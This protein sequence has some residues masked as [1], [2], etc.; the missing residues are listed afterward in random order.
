MKRKKD[1]DG[2][3]EDKKC[4]KVCTM[5]LNFFSLN[6]GWCCMTVS[7]MSRLHSSIQTQIS[8]K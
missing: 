7:C 2:F 5:K 1:N 4:G 8:G 3:S 6:Q